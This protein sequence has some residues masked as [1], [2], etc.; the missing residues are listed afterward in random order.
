MKGITIEI[1]QDGNIEQCRELC[2]ELMAFQ[3]SKARIEPLRFDAM[4]FDTRMRKSYDSAL[5]KQVVLVKDDGVPVGYVFSTVDSLDSMR[6][7]PFHLLPPRDDMPPKIGCLSNLYL[8]EKYRGTGLGSTLF[9]MSMEWLD[10]FPD[11]PLIYVF[12][13]NGN[14]DAYRFYTKHGFAYSHDVMGGFIKAVCRE[15]KAGIFSDRPR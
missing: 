10:S 14:D 8:R 6:S 9:D 12:I 13:S 5:D 11:V 7:S 15:R 1:V 3:K 4:N 2:D